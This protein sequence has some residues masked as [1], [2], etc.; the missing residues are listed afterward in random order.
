MQSANWLPFFLRQSNALQSFFFLIYYFFSQKCAL[1]LFNRCNIQ[2]INSPYLNMSHFAPFPH[3]YWYLIVDAITRSNGMHCAANS[4]YYHQHL[5]FL[6]SFKIYVSDK[7]TNNSSDRYTVTQLNSTM[8][9][10]ICPFLEEWCEKKKK[11]ENPWKRKISRTS[12]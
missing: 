3:Y 4:Y 10:E 9:G 1:H 12:H 11:N 6:F 2:Y 7:W 8:I 5:L